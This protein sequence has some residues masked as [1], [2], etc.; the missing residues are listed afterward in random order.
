MTRHSAEFEFSPL[1]PL[2]A[3]QKH[4]VR[5]GEMRIA[6]LDHLEDSEPVSSRLRAI[7]H[8]SSVIRNL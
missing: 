7:G 4:H 3:R 8:I 2:I 1:S 6:V 5:V